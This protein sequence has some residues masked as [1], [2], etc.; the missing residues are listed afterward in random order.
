MYDFVEVGFDLAFKY[1]NPVMIQADGIIGQM[2]EKVEIGEEKQ[3]RTPEAILKQCP[4][5]TTGK[6]TTRERNI[7]T[8]LDLVAA[9]AGRST[10]INLSKSTKKFRKKK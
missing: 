7:I 3:R 5:A 4:W 2:M 6:P 9:Q 10:T 8:S 1:R